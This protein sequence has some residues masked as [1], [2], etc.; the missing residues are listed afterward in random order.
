MRDVAWIALGWLGVIFW[1]A[2]G[3]RLVW[4]HV[5]PDCAVIVMI[6]LAVRRHIL[7][8]VTAS[9][10]LGYLVG[11]Q[12]GAPTGLHEFVLAGVALAAY[13][14]VGHL[15]AGGALFF[16]LAAG[17]AV[18]VYHVGLA[19]V[20]T[21]LGVPVGFSSPWTA[22][23]LPSALLTALVAALAHGPMERIDRLWGQDKTEELGWH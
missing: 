4:G 13:M 16:G 3:A 15:V 11:R 5:L 6:F 14:V 20:E 17:V 18:A 7:V 8:V 1:T 9:L 23:L 22:A 19:L 21:T 10:V 2:L 12:A